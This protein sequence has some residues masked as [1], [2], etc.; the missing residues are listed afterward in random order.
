[1][2]EEPDCCQRKIV[3]LVMALCAAVALVLLTAY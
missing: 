2:D 3:W 1:M